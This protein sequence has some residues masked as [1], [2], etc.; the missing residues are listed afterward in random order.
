VT[1]GRRSQLTPS[2]VTWVGIAV[3]ITLTLVKVIVGITFR[4]Q[5]LVADGLHS[6]SDLITDSAVLIGLRVSAKPADS[7]HHY[8][9]RRVTTLVTM[10]V[11]GALLVTAVWIVYKAIATYRAPHAAISA[12]VPFWVALCSIA[13]KEILYRLTRAVGI[14]VGNASLIANAWHHRT[15]AF[16][17]AAAA[18]GL[19]G[20]AF[21]GP[22][23]AFLDHLTAVVLS[24]FLVV[25]AIRFIHGSLSE[26][27]DA[28]PE[29]SITRCIEDAISET[30]GVLGFHALRVRKVGGF[31]ALDVHV[32]V[33]PQSTVVAGHDVATNVKR[34]VLACGCDVVEAVVHVEPAENPPE[35]TPE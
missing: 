16:T 25:A 12:V 1:R 18:V 15:D 20:V 23:W 19:A 28:A 24:S 32:Q 7:D 27:I 8:G 9:H 3:N 22:S 30:H 35:K 11:G 13:P 17:S 10:L 34:R 21:G 31:L 5:T 4:S 14:E 33:D 6:V 29:V 26:L 2:G